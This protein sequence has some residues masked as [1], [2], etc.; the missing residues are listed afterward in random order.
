MREGE[1]RGEAGSSG[2]GVWMRYT[3]FPPLQVNLFFEILTSTCRDE[4]IFAW[5]VKQGIGCVMRCIGLI[6]LPGMELFHVLIY[7]YRHFPVPGSFL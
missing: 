1:G 3:P 7:K 2:R 5:F 6:V 4:E